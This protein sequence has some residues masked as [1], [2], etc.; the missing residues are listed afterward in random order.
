MCRLDWR[1]QRPGSPV[2]Q[3]PSSCWT[4]WSW[5]AR[6]SYS[7]RY[8][9][10]NFG[11]T[12]VRNRWKGKAIHVERYLEIKD[13]NSRA[14]WSRFKP[15]AVAYHHTNVR[16][17]RS[18]SRHRPGAGLARR[19]LRRG[20]RGGLGEKKPSSLFKG[21]REP[22]GWTGRCSDLKRQ[23]KNTASISWS[24]RDGATS[25]EM[26]LPGGCLG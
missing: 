10:I 22:M 14:G 6:R 5:S 26:G 1:L 24:C 11:F 20:F 19:K 21:I 12:M 8:S 15:G 17:H 16:V 13:H 3:R 2:P 4:S 9:I 23:S 25:N 7:C 18:Q